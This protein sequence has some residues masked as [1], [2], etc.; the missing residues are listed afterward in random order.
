M[1]EEIDAVELRLCG[2]IGQS[3]PQRGV[4]I[5]MYLS[6]PPYTKSPSSSVT[7]AASMISS[8]PAVMLVGSFA[9]GSA[10]G[11]LLDAS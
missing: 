4:G 1:L 2:I 9:G 5:I 7:G 8:C 3:E 6:S 10:I 11:K